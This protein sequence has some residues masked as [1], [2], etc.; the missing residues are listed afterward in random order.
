MVVTV[1]PCPY[2]QS[3]PGPEKTCNDVGEH[4]SL[5]TGLTR[6]DIWKYQV[7]GGDPEGRMSFSSRLVEK[8]LMKSLP[9]EP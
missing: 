3:G 8:G 1:H 2:M 6:S 4:E 7:I 9:C 5:R